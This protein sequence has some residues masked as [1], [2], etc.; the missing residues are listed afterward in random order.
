VL[1]RRS[2]VR[3][4]VAENRSTPIKLLEKLAEDVDVR[5]EVAGNPS[6]PIKLL[7]E[8]ARILQTSWIL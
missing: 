8:L 4:G 7:E 6:I 2:S 3:A 5:G 1:S